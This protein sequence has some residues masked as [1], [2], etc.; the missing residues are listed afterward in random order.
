MA[1]DHDLATTLVQA[2]HTNANLLGHRDTLGSVD[3]YL[4]GG[5]AQPGY[6]YKITSRYF[7]AGNIIYLLIEDY[8]CR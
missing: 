7:L 6:E 4:N 5:E 3:F 2:L 1:K 8:I